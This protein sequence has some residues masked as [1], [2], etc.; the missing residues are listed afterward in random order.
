[1][2]I[3]KIINMSKQINK[4]VIENGKDYIK[5][6]KKTNSLHGLLFG[7]LHTEKDVSMDTVAAGFNTL[8][9]REFK[10]IDTIA[11]QSFLNRYNSL[12]LEFYENV[13]DKI[14]TLIDNMNKKN[15]T[16][17]ILA[18][19][20]SDTSCSK[21]LADKNYK[22]NKNNNSVT[23]LNLGIY[24]VTK[25][26]P[27]MLE[28]V[29]HADERKAFLDFIKRK[30]D[31]DKSI[32]VFDRGF[33]G[34]EFF[35]KLEEL[36]L[37]YVCRLRYNMSFIPKDNVDTVVRCN[38]INIRV[39]TYKIGE[40]YYHLATNLLDKN[41]YKISTLM[42]IY[43][44]RWTIEEKFKLMKS[45]FHFQ[46]TNFKDDVSIKKS[47]YCQLI[48]MRLTSLFTHIAT[49]NKFKNGNNNK[50]VINC[51]TLIDG[52]YSRM[53]YYII[54]GK[55]NR[56]RYDLFQ[57]CYF[58]FITTNAG[59]NV[60]RI[61]VTTG[62]KWYVKQYAKKYLKATSNNDSTCFDLVDGHD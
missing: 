9:I 56:K 4:I 46:K 3:S 15:Y 39:V 25:N 58:V 62:M 21:S 29:N 33:D 16:H 54:F 53:L 5:R 6:N 11:R 61:C 24:N 43:H 10:A 17:Q 32:F 20:G 47:I 36:N 42:Q 8:N 18:V 51:K 57:K 27:I 12:P 50:R 19:D 30:N 31:F 40:N 34:S 49:N 52:L 38:N 13:S 45:N 60:P 48:I 37:R 22:L 14:G 59:K 23:A 55:L 1:M 44:D 35:K 7:L 2:M 28:M 26:L 41:E